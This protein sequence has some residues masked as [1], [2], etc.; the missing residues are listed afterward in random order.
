MYVFATE[1]PPVYFNWMWGVKIG[2]VKMA[3]MRLILMRL[4]ERERERE[5]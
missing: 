4:K 3:E 5:S 2:L 1:L